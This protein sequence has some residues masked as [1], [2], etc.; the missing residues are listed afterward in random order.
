MQ[1]ST[2][3]SFARGRPDWRFTPTCQSH[4]GFNPTRRLPNV[5][6]FLF[7]S[8]GC[9]VLGR[10]NRSRGRDHH[11]ERN[12]GGGVLSKLRGFTLIEI[13]L[14][15]VV[16]AAT[17]AALT[18]LVG[19]VR[20]SADA[21]LTKQ[22]ESIAEAL[23]DEVRLAGFTWCDPA[24]ANFDT[25]TSVSACVSV[26]EAMG[27]ETGNVRPYDNVND[28]NTFCNTPMAT[29]TDITGASLI[30]FAGYSARICI[31]PY[32]ID[33]S[34]SNP[35]TTANSL[36]VDITVSRSGGAGSFTLTGWRTRYAPNAS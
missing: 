5:R 9:L 25:A 8:G 3:G 7:H 1:H 2:S 24:D 29:I 32:A 31:T 35:I 30:A 34:T 20:N 19:M 16:I 12:H 28:Y 10:V 21:M 27:P 22:A 36:R 11:R 6:Q 14:A 17:I 4:R 13:I 23:M 18:P 15:M 26:P 33:L